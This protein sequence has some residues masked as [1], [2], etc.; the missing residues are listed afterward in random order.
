MTTNFDKWVEKM[1]NQYADDNN[2][3]IRLFGDKTYIGYNFKT[4]KS[5]VARCHSEDT[6]DSDI[7]VA[8]AYARCKGYDVPKQKVYKKLS[9]MKNGDK[10]HCS[11]YGDT[12]KYIGK[13]D[14]AFVVWDIDTKKYKSMPFDVEYEMVD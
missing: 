2:I 13:N 10:F 12:Y 5:F 4:H 6:F 1:V 14:D 8:I 11:I 9:E 7:G 3:L